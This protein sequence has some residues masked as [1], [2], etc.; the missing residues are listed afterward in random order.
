M[1]IQNA[2]L[3]IAALVNLIM[4]IIVFSRGLKNKVN[5]YFGSLTFFNFLW[6]L[7]LFFSRAFFLVSNYW[8]LY[9]S[10]TYVAAIGIVIFLYYFSIYFPIQSRKS[11]IYINYLLIFGGLILSV[12]IFLDN[13]FF[14]GFDIDTI[15][16]IYILH[17]NKITYLIYSLFFVGVVFLALYNFL[18]KLKNIELIF[19]KQ[20]KYFL[21]TIIIGI[22]LGTYFDLFLCYF[23]NFS[24]NWLGPIFTLPMNFVAFYLIFLINKNNGR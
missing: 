5:L 16:N 19:K 11:S 24:F 22:V 14:V 13:M 3:L 20:I 6:P 12:F 4:S 23:G 7:F 2:F 8:I 17:F 9:S 1:S 18:Y 15:N 10:L 21:I